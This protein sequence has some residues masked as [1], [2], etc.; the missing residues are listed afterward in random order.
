MV[1]GNTHLRDE[2]GPVQPHEMEAEE[3]MTQSWAR[4][5]QNGG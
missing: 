3:W 4:L 5:R 1:A 2:R